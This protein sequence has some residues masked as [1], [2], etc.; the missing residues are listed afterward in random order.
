[1]VEFTTAGIVVLLVTSTLQL[2]T[3]F[4]DRIQ[5]SKCRSVE[6][7]FNSD[8]GTTHTTHTTNNITNNYNS[9]EVISDDD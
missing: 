9:S 5:K 3:T 2:L 7:E 4:M 1:M 8:K 6:L